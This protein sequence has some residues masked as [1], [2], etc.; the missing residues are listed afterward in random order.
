[1]TTKSQAYDHPAYEVVFQ[2]Q[3]ATTTLTGANTIGIKYVAF[4]NLIIKAVTGWITTGGTS[5]DVMNVVKISGTTTTTQAYGTVGSGVTGVV[6]LTPSVAANQV[7]TLQG[8]MYYAQKG[9]D[10]T[11]TYTAAT[12]EY[13]VQPLGVLTV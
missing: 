7:T 4:S 3:A 2:Q 5:A 11:S 8:D 6:S 10:A 9:T 13:V 1:M 12:I